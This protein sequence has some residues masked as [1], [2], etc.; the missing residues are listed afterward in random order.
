MVWMETGDLF[1]GGDHAKE[2]H[3]RRR[4]IVKRG[5]IYLQQMFQIPHICFCVNAFKCKEHGAG[6]KERK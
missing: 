5:A 4:T 2:V 1:Y 6:G 3:L